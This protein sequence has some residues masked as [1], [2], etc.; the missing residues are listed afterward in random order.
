MWIQCIPY[1]IAWRCQLLVDFLWLARMRHSK[2][3]GE[4]FFVRICV[5]EEIS[6]HSED[7]L[8]LMFILTPIV[9][10]TSTVATNGWTTR[11]RVATWHRSQD[12]LRMSTKGYWEN[13][14]V[15][16]LSLLFLHKSVKYDGWVSHDGVGFSGI[17][18]VSGE[19]KS[20]VKST[21]AGLIDGHPQP[22]NFKCISG[23]VVQVGI[24]NTF[25]I[26]TV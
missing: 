21:Y 24:I 8:Q 5:G 22:K 14:V 1:R 23:Y 12:C 15:R 11:N 13:W 4:C 17:P 2:W 9:R 10:W 20:L 26:F 25:T 18:V 19:P 3:P 7:Q 6:G 16:Q